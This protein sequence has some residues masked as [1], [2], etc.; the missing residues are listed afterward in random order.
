MSDLDTF[1]SPAIETNTSGLDTF[2]DGPYTE[3]PED[4][5]TEDVTTEDVQDK[6]QE[7]D[8][9]DGQE[10][11][12]GEKV[13]TDSQ[14]NNLEE[15]EEKEEAKREEES[16]KGD[17]ESDSDDEKSDDEQ[18]DDSAPE[19]ED[20]APTGKS[21]KAFL[22]GKK[23]E[24][25]ENAE[26]KVKVDGK[27]EKVSLTELRDNYSGKQSWDKKFNELSAERK[28]H[29]EEREQYVQERDYIR[30][31]L[32]GIRQAAD[33]A[34]DGEGSPM[35]FVD[36]VLDM[37]N[38]DSYAFNR[39]MRDYLQEEFEIMSDMT[40]IEKEAYWTKKENE[41]LVKQKE[42]LESRTAEE[43]ANTEFRQHVE[44][45]R[46]S[47]DV[48]EEQFTS[49]YQDLVELGQQPTP[50]DV[51]GY[52]RTLQPTIQAEKLIEPYEDQLSDDE[53]DDLVVSIAQTLRDDPEIT[54]DDIRTYLAEQLEVDSIVSEIKE[55]APSKEDKGSFVKDE[56]KHSIESFDDYDEW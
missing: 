28:E 8:Q 54:E 53:A 48:S 24:I 12:S 15:K 3:G 32:Q 46:Q 31:E 36:K 5:G 10:E 43:K 27:N 42:N 1:D 20:N 26:I 39:K 33:K 4:E 47:H 25:P 56:K 45:L 23:Y 21:F 40:E 19:N 50:E 17:K 6:E 16:D 11:D 49:A 29:Q 35:E 2:D 14:V 7:S 9:E 30:G 41:Y 55:K 13:D 34:M 22:D 37:M 38:I 18:T 51:V 44:S 52:A